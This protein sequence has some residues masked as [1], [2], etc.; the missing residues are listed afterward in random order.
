LP[1]VRQEWAQ[2]SEMFLQAAVEFAEKENL[3]FINIYGRVKE[4][5]TAGKSIRWF[6]DQNDNIHPSRLAYEMTADEI[7]KTLRKYNIVI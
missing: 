3:P 6:I 7:G 1:E 5:V 4:E 2:G